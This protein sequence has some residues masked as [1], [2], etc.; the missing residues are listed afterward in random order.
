VTQEINP[1]VSSL[2]DELIVNPL[3]AVVVVFSGDGIVSEQETPPDGGIH[4]MLDR[5]FICRKHLSPSQPRHHST[6]FTVQTQTSRYSRPGLCFQ[7]SVC[8][9]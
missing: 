5:H 6:S 2:M 9:R 7:Q 3:L 4:D 1:E 8:Q